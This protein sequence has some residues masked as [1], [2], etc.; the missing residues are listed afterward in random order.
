MPN[1]T[2]PRVCIDFDGTEAPFAADPVLPPGPQ[3]FLT[4]LNAT[5]GGLAACPSRIGV[6]RTR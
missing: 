1:F 6:R 4:S 5:T 2:A 3:F